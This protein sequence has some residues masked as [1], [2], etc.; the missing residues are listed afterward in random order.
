MLHNPACTAPS[1]SCVVLDTNI[2]IESRLLRSPLGAALLF[3]LH[4]SRARIGLP[5]VVEL[6]ISKNIVNRCADAIAGIEKNYAWLDSIVGACDYTLPTGEEVERAIKER[7]DCLLHSSHRISF[8]LEHAKAAL[9]RVNEGTPPN[10]AK[11]QQFKDSAIWEAI[12]ELASR[13]TVHFVTRD[14]A[15]Y[16]GRDTRQGLASNLKS[17]CEA[18]GRDVHLHRDLTTLLLDLQ[19]ASPP[20]GYDYQFIAL[21]LA[22]LFRDYW[23]EWAQRK[24]FQ[25]GELKSQEIS[26]FTTE[27]EGSLALGFEFNFDAVDL[28][29]GENLMKNAGTLVVKG[30]GNHEFVSRAV[31][32]AIIESIKYFKPDGGELM[33]RGFSATLGD[34]GLQEARMATK[35]K[36][37][38]REI[39][40]VRR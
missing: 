13:Y 30:S 32:S 24:G 20:V 37:H 14:A 21:K 9:M 31:P 39:I 8:T 29:A 4:H 40:R 19:A 34:T 28:E 36:V 3:W 33:E 15:F 12:L 27:G 16:D 26:A 2:W 17:Q 11:D 6:E 38:S 25:I 1:P 7:L 10:G 5:E 23:Q 35:W 18:L 22:D